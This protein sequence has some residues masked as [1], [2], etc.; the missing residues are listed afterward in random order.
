MFISFAVL[1]SALQTLSQSVPNKEIGAQESPDTVTFQ[2][3]PVLFSN[4][5]TF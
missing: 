4:H 1:V 5:I 2:Y 3:I